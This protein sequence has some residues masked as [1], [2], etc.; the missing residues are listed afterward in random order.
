M[1]IL[2]S[3][4]LISLF[5]ILLLTLVSYLI[6]DSVT[7]N[8]EE[9]RSYECG[10]EHHNLSRVPF[11]LR[12]FFLTLIFLLFDLEIILMIFLPY[13]IFSANL[14]FVLLVVTSFVFILFL[15][16]IYEWIDGSLE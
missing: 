3:F 7:L 16:L 5:L 2:F 15:G 11:S 14:N 12:Y 6:S 8:R 13:S 9:L 10:F 1:F 4:L